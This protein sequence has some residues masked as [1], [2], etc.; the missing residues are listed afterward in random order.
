MRGHGSGASMRALAASLVLALGAGAAGA[1]VPG[2]L[3]E[4]GAPVYPAYEGW[5]EN[6]DGSITLLAG[7]FN[8]NTRE[9][10]DVSGRARTT[11]SS[12]G[13]RTRASRRTSCP[14]GPGAPSRSGYRATIRTAGWYGI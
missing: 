3:Q 2:T 11:T 9:I 6:P 14:A 5:Y 7:Y 8:A 1:Q 13:R 4:F 10:A 12:R